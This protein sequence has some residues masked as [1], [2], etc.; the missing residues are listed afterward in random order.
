MDEEL[1]KSGIIKISYDNIIRPRDVETIPYDE[2][3]EQVADT[4]LK[5]FCATIDTIK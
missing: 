3:L 5:N 4:I 1:L 2:M